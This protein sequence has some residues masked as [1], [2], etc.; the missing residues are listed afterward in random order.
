MD[1]DRIRALID[2]MAAAPIAEL[3][4]EEGPLRVRLV[5]RPSGGPAAAPD[6]PA[7]LP[8]ESAGAGTDADAAADAVLAPMAGTFYRAPAPGA[9]PFVAVGDRVGAGQTLA[10]VEAMK[11]LVKVEAGRAGSVRAILAGDAE[12]VEEG[13][14]LLVVG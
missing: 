5:R 10:L 8:R 9:P 4:V 2:L 11:T 12:T 7:T 6:G 13:Q 14:P 1:L 3:E